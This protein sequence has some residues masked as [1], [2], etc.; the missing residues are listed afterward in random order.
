MSSVRA[1]LTAPARARVGE[2]VQIS[3]LVQHPMETGYRQGPDKEPLPRDLIRRVHARFDGELVFAAELHAAI[4]ANPYLS[5]DMRL[6]RSGVL[7]V[8]W[9][10]D[11]GLSHTESQRIDAV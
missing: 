4:A 3:A 9:T 1:I 8:V 10:G 6:P 2:V 7:S 5:F 11:R